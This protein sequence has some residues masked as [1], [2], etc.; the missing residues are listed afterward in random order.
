MK[1]FLSWS[2]ERSRLVAAALREWL[3]DVVH[4]LEPWM[5]KRDIGSG[6]RWGGEVGAQLESADFGILCMTAE[7]LAAPWILFE[8][9]ALAKRLVESRVIPFLIG[10][11][12]SDIPAGPLT[13]FQAKRANEEETWDIVRDLNSALGADA[14]DE[15]RLRRIFERTW[16]DLKKAIEALPPSLVPKPPLNLNTAVAEILDTTRGLARGVQDLRTAAFNGTISWDET[17]RLDRFWPMPYVTL[18][19]GISGDYGPWGQPLS[20]GP[21]L[22]AVAR[23]DGVRYAWGV[24]SGVNATGGREEII[25]VRTNS[26]RPAGDI[27]RDIEGLFGKPVRVGTG[28]RT[29]LMD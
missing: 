20:G 13:Q 11:E 4:G 1:V 14:V 25:A 6:A 27:R 21:Q 16:P 19:F 3:P 26:K 15:A 9:G 17:D 18:F 12:P 28:R 29:V 22:D 23:V 7:N 5:S 2:D 24:G 10:V 8:A